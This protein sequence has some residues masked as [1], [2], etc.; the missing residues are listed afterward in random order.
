MLVAKKQ[1]FE[2]YRRKLSFPDGVAK[3]TFEVVL[4]RR[5]QEQMDAK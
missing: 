5:T 4:T 1:G 2:T 3:S